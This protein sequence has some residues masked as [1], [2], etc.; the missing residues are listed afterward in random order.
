MIGIIGALDVEITVIK[1]L[2]T[3]VR[4]ETISKINFY[5]GKISGQDCVLAQCGVAKVNAAMC[6][7][8]MILMFKPEA[9][10]N[11]GV[12]G[13]LNKEINIGDIVVSSSVVHH[14]A[15][16]IEDEGKE[17]GMLFPRGT[18]QFSDE[19]ITKID[20]DKALADRLIEGC[21]NID[22]VKVFYGTV[23][24]GEQFISS[25]VARIEIGEFFNA[26]CCEMEGAAIG[27]VCYRNDVPFVILR[28]I[29][30]TIDD[31]DFMDFEKFKCIAADE[32][33]KVIKAFFNVEEK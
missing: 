6:T 12:A 18:I 27:Q 14:D 22:G 32:T 30:D 9:I 11:T 13:A 15:N 20:A 23:A 1:N 5:I 21:K 31:N 2:M 4:E 16:I 7:Q 19:S 29:S 3:D 25:K 8:T 17:S 24:S 10:I 28:A 33:L 26:Y